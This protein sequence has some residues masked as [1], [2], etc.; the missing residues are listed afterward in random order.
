MMKFNTINN[1]DFQNKR[2][3]IRVDYN[4]PLNQNLKVLDDTRIISS[5]NTIK[6][7]INQGG[8]CILIS[9]MGRPK[10]KKTFKF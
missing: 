1:V 4:V 6:K 10:G 9:H 8:S 3:L 7:I 5:M 2:A